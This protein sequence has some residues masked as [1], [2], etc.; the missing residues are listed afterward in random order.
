MKKRNKHPDREQMI[1]AAET[2]RIPFRS[3]LAECPDCRE[4]YELLGRFRGLVDV[5]LV[6]P[7]PDVMS[8]HSFIPQLLQSREQARTISGTVEFDSW[9]G[10]PALALRDAARG[11]ERRMRLTAGPVSL[12]LVAERQ[13]R[14]WEFTARVYQ[15]G[16]VSSGFILEAG[17]KQLYPGRRWCFRW[18]AAKP[19]RKL[20]LRS[21]DLAIDFGALNWKHSVS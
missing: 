8:R 16:R 12:E 7:P 6:M 18:T 4:L 15:R 20:G 3:H 17:R 13:T 21:A 11:M 14:H 2:G 5:D 1:K 9:S 19:P 10:L